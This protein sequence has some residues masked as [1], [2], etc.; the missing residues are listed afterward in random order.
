MKQFMQSFPDRKEDFENYDESDANLPFRYVI[1]KSMIKP[2]VG[3]VDTMPNLGPHEVEAF[4]FA[5]IL[6]VGYSNIMI[7][8]PELPFQFR[9]K[10]E[11]VSVLEMQDENEEKKMKVPRSMGSRMVWKVASTRLAIEKSQKVGILSK[12]RDLFV[13]KLYIYY[14][15]RKFDSKVGV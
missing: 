7:R 11:E 3:F 9:K 8:A 1:R 5:L 6:R 12:V 4:S 15:A 2:I 10:A 14:H 13:S